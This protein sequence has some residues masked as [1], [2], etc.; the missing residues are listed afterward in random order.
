MCISCFSSGWRIYERA[1]ERARHL[2]ETHVP[3]PLPDGA[4]EAMRAIVEEAERELGVQGARPL[5]ASA[6]EGG[7]A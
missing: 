5:R 3:L 7:R 4:A 1:A 6:S 2:I